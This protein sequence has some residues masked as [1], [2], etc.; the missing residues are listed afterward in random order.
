MTFEN[1]CLIEPSDFISVL[2]ECG[3]CH[4]AIVVPID[5]IDENL[6]STYAV[7]DCH[8]C[9]AQTGYTKGTPEMTAFLDFNTALKRFVDLSKG[10]DL[11]MRLNIKCTE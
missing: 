8:Y 5:K 11:K 3:K 4:A 1:R 6:A 10:R 2:Y 9:G 7:R